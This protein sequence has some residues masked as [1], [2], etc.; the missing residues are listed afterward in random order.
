MKFTFPAEGGGLG[1]TGI[2]HSRFRDERRTRAVVQ[3][4]KR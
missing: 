2:E 3:Q 1:G 4:K